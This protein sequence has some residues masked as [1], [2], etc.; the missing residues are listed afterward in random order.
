MKE[1]LYNLAMIEAINFCKANNIDCSGT[2]LYK[3]PRKFIYALLNDKT[4]RA[5][6]TVKLHKNQVPTHYITNNIV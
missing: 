1:I 2:H 6:V 4:G 5:V 3:Y